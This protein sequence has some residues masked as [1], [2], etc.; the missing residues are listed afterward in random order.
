[1]KNFLFNIVLVPAC[2]GIWLSACSDNADVV[3]VAPPSPLITITSN[4]EAVSLD[5]ENIRPEPKEIFHVDEHP[6]RRFL[7]HNRI[8][9]EQPQEATP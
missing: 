5:A 2:A 3:V 8:Q 7:R 1:M 9:Q 4:V 6:F